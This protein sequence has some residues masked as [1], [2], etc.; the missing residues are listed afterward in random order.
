[1]LLT[2]HNKLFGLA[3]D[4]KGEA[5]FERV[6]G[7]IDKDNPTTAPVA[8]SNNHKYL[9]TIG[10]HKDGVRASLDNKLI[11]EWKTDYKDLS[12]YAVWKLPD[13]KLC[14]LGANNGRWRFIRWR[15]WNWRERGGRRAER[16]IGE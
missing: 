7:K 2:S 5:R 14:A 1:M 9:L 3:L 4:V 13:D 16:G 12:R 6:G 11:T 15:L 8:I 10:I